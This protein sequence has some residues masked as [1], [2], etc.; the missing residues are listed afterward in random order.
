MRSE[1]D[2]EP[3][4]GARTVPLDKESQQIE[5][6]TTGRGGRGRGSESMALIKSHMIGFPAT[7]VYDRLCWRCY[8]CLL[9]QRGWFPTYTLQ[10]RDGFIAA[11][12]E[13]I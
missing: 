5:K 3:E 2:E 12:V 6:T 10:S 9:L 13:Q 4:L 11:G 7:R 1:P 8:N